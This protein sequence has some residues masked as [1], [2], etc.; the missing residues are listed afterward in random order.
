MAFWM[1]N[2]KNYSEL[3]SNSMDRPLSLWDRISVKLHQWMCPPCNHLN[4]QFT[5][6]R[7]ACRK[8]SPSADDCAEEDAILPD[9]VCL[10]MKTALKNM[11][12]E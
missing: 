10:R 12:K 4:E 9:E 8:Q 1:I 5:A 6:I 2:C 7:E 3:V 11:T